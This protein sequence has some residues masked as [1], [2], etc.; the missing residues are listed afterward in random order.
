[1]THGASRHG[2][3]LGF[4]GLGFRCLGFIGF[5]VQGLGF[6]GLGLDQGRQKR[7]PDLLPEHLYTV[8]IKYSA[9]W[10]TQ[11]YG[12]KLECFNT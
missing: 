3:C 11:R 10:G 6:R 4:R 12:P 9:A 2:L 8:G 7:F 1:M 5:R